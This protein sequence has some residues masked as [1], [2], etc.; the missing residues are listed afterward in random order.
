MPLKK[1]IFKGAEITF[2]SGINIF[3]GGPTDILLI[4]EELS[5]NYGNICWH[6][7]E[8]YFPPKAIGKAVKYL[9]KLRRL[10]M[11]FFLTTNS[12]VLLKEFDLRSKKQDQ[13]LY[14]SLFYDDDGTFKVN[15]ANSF[16]IIHPNPILDV[17][18][19]I[20]ER[21]IERSLGGRGD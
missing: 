19:D 18:T 16:A 10:G 3:I 13:I 20:Y 4:L 11:Q 1:I 7:P 2:S 5:F 21:D 8:L 6:L 9:L 14:H 17:Y 12:Y 15:T